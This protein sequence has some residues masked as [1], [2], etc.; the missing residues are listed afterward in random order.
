MRVRATKRFVGPRS[1]DLWLLDITTK[2]KLIAAQG[3][4]LNMAFDRYRIAETSKEQVRV[5]KGRGDRSIEAIP[6]T[7][8][9]HQ[10]RC[11]DICGR[12]NVPG[13]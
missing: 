3:V 10:S 4:S 8:E 5:I 1:F 7:K 12:K 6:V 13:V 11:C 9:S 2:D